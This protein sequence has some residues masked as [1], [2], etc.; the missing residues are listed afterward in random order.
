MM[1]RI[2]LALLAAPLI[3]SAVQCTSSDVAVAPVASK[4]S[5]LPGQPWGD[6]FMLPLEFGGDSKRTLHFLFDTGANITVLDPDALRSVS[7]WE[8]EVGSNVR[9]TDV[10][11]GVVHFSKLPAKVVELDHL[12]RALGWPIDGIL[13]FPAFAD[14]LV[15]LDYETMRMH[16][17]SG[18][19]PPPDGQ[20]VFELKK[21]SNRRPWVDLEVGRRR[22]T[23]LLDSGSGGL[24]SL[25]RTTTDEWAVPPREV[26][27]AMGIQGLEYRRVGRMAGPMR[28]FGL[29]FDRPAVQAVSRGSDLIGTRYLKHFVLTFDQR[30]GRVRVRPANVELER[31]KV[32]EGTGVLTEPRPDG[33]LVRALTPGSP[34]V[35]A[36][37]QVGDLIQTVS[38]TRFDRW[39]AGGFER[40]RDGDRTF[41]R[42]Q[43]IRGG[44]ESVVEVDWVDLLELPAQK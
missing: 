26:G 41:H 6:Y 39:P 43:L 32:V 42:Y 33:L 21:T 28:L 27:T 37:I 14:L 17:A 1:R 24:L 20:S 30:H 22:R 40:L 13:G 23:V 8:G 44:R 35:A 5:T 34:A 2:S 7:G 31:S 25:K 38:G 12:S 15:T 29:E 10:D 11:C 18:A 3:L 4:G 9:L 19:L 16:V 36:G